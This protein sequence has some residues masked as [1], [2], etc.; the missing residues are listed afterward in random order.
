MLSL[1][2]FQH[3]LVV[4]RWLSLMFDFSRM[5]EL[6]LKANKR[7]SHFLCAVFHCLR[8][9]LGKHCSFCMSPSENDLW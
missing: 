2:D 3:M 9:I 5:G 8:A 1:E 7:N 6:F 4:F